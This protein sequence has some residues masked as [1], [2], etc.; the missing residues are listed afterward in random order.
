MMGEPV[1]VQCRELQNHVLACRRQFAAAQTAALCLLKHLQQFPA[2]QLSIEAKHCSV[3]YILLYKIV[4]ESKHEMVYFIHE[5]AVDRENPPPT[6]LGMLSGGVV[7]PTAAIKFWGLRLLSLSVVNCS[8]RRCSK[9]LR[10]ISFRSLVSRSIWYL[11]SFTCAWYMFSS[12]AMA[13][14]C[15]VFSRKFACTESNAS[16]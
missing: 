8:R 16:S 13:L 9:Y 12:L 11:Y 10:F 5:A 15:F 3:R 2:S 7:P 1:R 6:N 4:M 14:I